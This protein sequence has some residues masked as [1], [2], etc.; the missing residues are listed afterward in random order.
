[1]GGE[2][3]CQGLRLGQGERGEAKP[4]KVTERGREVRESGG[5]GGGSVV[6]GPFRGR[7]RQRESEGR[8]RMA[9]SNNE[10]RESGVT[11]RVRDD[12]SKDE[13]EGAAKG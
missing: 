6:Q 1:M 12:G 9:I 5:G 7:K 2:R 3:E 4:E 11:S 8:G 10:G 13:E